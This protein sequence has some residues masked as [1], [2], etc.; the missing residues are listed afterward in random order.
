M[1]L[2]IDT[3]NA[4]GLTPLMKACSENDFEE[5]QILIDKGA[6]VDQEFDKSGSSKGNT[7]LVN[8]NI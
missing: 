7:A 8:I 2:N 6:A 3:P 4:N 5:A 1:L